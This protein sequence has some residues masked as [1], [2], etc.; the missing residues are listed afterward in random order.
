MTTLPNGRTPAPTDTEGAL[1]FE[2]RSPRPSNSA[3]IHVA[4][5]GIPVDLQVSDKKIADIEQLIN[6]LLKRGWQAPPMPKGGGGFGGQ[7]R[8]KPAY[9]DGGNPCCP[10]HNKRLSE[11]EWEGRKFWSCPAKADQGK[12]EKANAKGY[13]SLKFD[14]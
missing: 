6:G 9:D 2:E 10:I 13:C 5:Q 3:V 14:V 7:P 11:R 1:S 8:T 12:G 4:F